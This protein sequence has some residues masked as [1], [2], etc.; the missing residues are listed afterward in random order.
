MKICT[1]CGEEKGLDLF[2]LNKKGERGRLSKCRSCKNTA[3]RES[4]RRGGDRVRRLNR[5][6]KRRL[7]KKNPQANGLKY[8]LR[9]TPCSEFEAWMNAS[10]ELGDILDDQLTDEDIERLDQ[11]EINFNPSVIEGAT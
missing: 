3:E 5:E 2:P 11:E 9:K 4:Y 1:R 6:Y 10:V 8:A 7:L